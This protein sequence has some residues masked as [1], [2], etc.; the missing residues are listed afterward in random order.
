MLSKAMVP[1]D[2]TEI[3]E[4]IIPFVAQ[5]SRGLDMPVVLGTAVEPDP[6]W[7]GLPDR[8]TVDRDEP[9]HLRER[10]EREVMGR[11]RELADSLASEGAPPETVV[12]YGPVSEA[13]IRMAQDTGCDLIAMS[14]R[15]RGVISS[16]LL[17]SVT[18]RIMHE[19]PVPVLAITPERAALHSVS[20]HGLNRVVVPLDGSELAEAVLP[21]AASLCRGMGMTMVLLHVLPT[22]D[23][24]Y[25]DGFT[26]SEVVTATRQA[27][28]DETQGYLEGIAR[29]MQDEGINSETVVIEGKPSSVIT[30][31]A[32]REEGSMIALATHGRSG[33]SRLLLGSVAEAVVRESGD[34]VLVVRASTPVTPDP[35]DQPSVSTA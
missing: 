8:L 19:S 2:G 13:I 9:G 6:M 16:G 17:G 25:S 10:I 31:V 24:V 7:A 11:L 22:Y 4:G 5:L 34:P 18:Y 14:T 26:L 29:Q 3:S 20:D 35:A 21:Y 33:V 12:R 30:A 23:M 32:R 27:V 1:L 28:E 15:G